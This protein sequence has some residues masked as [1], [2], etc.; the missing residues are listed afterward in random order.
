MLLLLVQRDKAE[1]T[2]VRGSPV[3]AVSMRGCAPVAKPPK[4]THC[5]LLVLATGSSM[6][7]LRQGPALAR[8]KRHD[9]NRQ[10]QATANMARP[11]ALF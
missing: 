6:S 1:V 5:L 3:W 11:P 2:A 8:P 7:G 4:T 9:P 10:G